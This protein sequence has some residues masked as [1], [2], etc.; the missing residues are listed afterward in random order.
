MKMSRKVLALTITIAILIPMLFSI[1]VEASGTLYV[2]NKSDV[3]VWSSASSSS[4]RIRLLPKGKLISIILITTNAAGNQW[5]RTANNTYIYMGNLSGSNTTLPSVGLYMTKIDSVPLRSQPSSSATTI[6]RIGINK[7]LTLIDTFYTDVG[8]PWGKTADGYFVY[9]GNVTIHTH[10]AVSCGLPWHEYELTDDRTHVNK[11]LYSEYCICGFLVKQTI[12]SI[13]QEQHQ[14]LND[15]C[16]SCD[17]VKRLV[18]V[19]GASITSDYGNRIHPITGEYTFHYGV[20]IVSD[21]GNDQIMAIEKGTVISTGFDSAAGY[22]VVIKHPNGYVSVYEHLNI[23]GISSGSSVNRGDVI[24]QMGSTGAS[25]GKHLHL[26]IRSSWSNGLWENYKA[27]SIN[28]TTYI[29]DLSK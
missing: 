18:P 22:F 25:E 2:T 4:T 10:K 8:T 13:V 12:S 20:D 19:H 29:A 5:G 11:T 6:K 14:F 7:C 15:V 26:G 3:P 23:I 9:L 17:H 28:P 1:T 27:L 24:G 16:Q 21:T